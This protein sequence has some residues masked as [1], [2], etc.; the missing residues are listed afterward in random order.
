ME[1]FLVSPGTY[2]MNTPKAH[3]GDR[4]C[5]KEYEKEKRGRDLKQ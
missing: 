4:N 1:L 2:V 5:E 3:I